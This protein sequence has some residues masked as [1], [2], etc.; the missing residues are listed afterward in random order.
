MPAKLTA[1]QAKARAKAPDLPPL[2]P[3]QSLLL[4]LDVSS[5]AI[6]WALT[7]GPASLESF[8]VILPDRPSTATAPERIDSMVRKLKYDVYPIG[9]GAEVCM[10]WA[11]GKMARRVG[12]A[13]GLSVLGAAQ[14]TIRRVLQEMGHSTV[15]LVSENEWTGSK[16]KGRRA[17]E[18]ALR[19]PAYGEFVRTGRDSGYDAADAVGL[20]VY[21]WS[22]VA[23]RRMIELGSKRP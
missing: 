15:Y 3:G 18:M 7:T 22:K 4:T 17:A 1:R 8:G 14:G 11:S 5:S 13:T 6:G 20:A 9:R 19:F 2:V 10:E 21:V 16:A 12:R 23:E